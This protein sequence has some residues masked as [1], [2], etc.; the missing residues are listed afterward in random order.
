MQHK[1][2]KD[3]MSILSYLE[4]QRIVQ[5]Q[6]IKSATEYRSKYKELSLP[7][8]PNRTYEDKGWISWD[9]F[10]GKQPDIPY[11]QAQQ[12][13]KE[14]GILTFAEYKLAWK[15]LGL[16]SHPQR[17]YKDSGWS[18]WNSFFGKTDF[19]S[20]DDAQKIVW[21][22]GIKSYKDYRTICKDYA[23]PL[24]PEEYYKGKGWNGWRAFLG[25]EKKYPTYEEAKLV[26]QKMGLKNSNDYRKTY[27][28]IVYKDYVFPSDP[29][30]YY[31][32]KGWI[33]WTDFLGNSKVISQEDRKNNLFKKLAINPTLLRDAPLKVLFIYFS[34]FRGIS[35]DITSLLS[36]SSYEERLNWVKEQLNSLKD[37]SLSK[38][39]SFLEEPDE[40]SAMKSVL[41]ENDDVKK[42]FS[43]GDTDRF[44]TLL[45][46]YVH[47][48]VN[49]ELIAEFD[50]R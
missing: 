19:L 29:F 22:K 36:T 45:E 1:L 18:T 2:N 34:K 38:D 39:K 42:S 23:L 50:D 15:E 3:N 41:E 26:V 35:D 11:L 43:V 33:S 37:G 14:K 32:D 7:S 46:N 21:E 12:I 13:V 47:S 40:L 17:T 16:P 48:V 10:F 20:Y 5:S 27:K 6:G 4:A 31:K 24:A 25:N 30:S 8:N 28:G 44:N 9:D 49:R